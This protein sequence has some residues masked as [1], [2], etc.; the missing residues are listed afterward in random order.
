[1]YMYS[2]Y[3]Y[4]Y[5]FVVYVRIF[6]ILKNQ[7]SREISSTN[8]KFQDWNRTSPKIT[9]PITILKQLNIVSFCISTFLRFYIYFKH[10]SENKKPEASRLKFALYKVAYNTI[11]FCVGKIFLFYILFLRQKCTF[12]STANQ[13]FFQLWNNLGLIYF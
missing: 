5:I 13:I 9:R 8:M 4:I 6:Y 7:T 12:C 1:M 3:I 10:R 2:I 11:K